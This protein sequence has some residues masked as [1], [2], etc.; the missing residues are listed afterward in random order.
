MGLRVTL[1]VSL[2][3]VRIT[4]V[5]DLGGFVQ[6]LGIAALIPGLEVEIPVGGMLVRPFGEVGF[7]RSNE[8]SKV[9]Y[10]VG[11]RAQTTADL[12]TLHFRYG[13]MV[14]GRRTT[15]LA[16]T[17]D[18]YASFEGGADMQVPLGFNVRGNEA[19]G[20]IY[21]IGRAFDGLELE[22]EDQPAIVL[23]GQFE[24]GLSFATAPELR[25]WRIPLRWLAAGYQFGRFSGVRVYLT[26][27]F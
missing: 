15:S 12:N 27:P 20:G 23:G 11:L 5:S 7:G 1:P 17:A 8:A 13:G 3:S 16:G 18:R 2:S 14:S 25:I 4:G 19:R 9:F 21:V 10:G 26:F 22:R 6:K 24:A